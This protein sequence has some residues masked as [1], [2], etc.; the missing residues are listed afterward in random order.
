MKKILA[1]LITAMLLA[2]LFGCTTIEP[3]PNGDDTNAQLKVTNQK[4]A[5]DALSDVST[6]I[7]GINQSLNEI[8]DTLTK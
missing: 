3:N 5:T 6:D 7:S 1:I 4:E 2:V 8:D